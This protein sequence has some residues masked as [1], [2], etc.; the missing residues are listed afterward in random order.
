MVINT[1]S[2]GQARPVGEQVSTGQLHGALGFMSQ[3]TIGAS[4]NGILEKE[5][6]KAFPLCFVTC[7][8]TKQM[9]KGTILGHT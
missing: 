3:V 1:H 5:R 9:T 4:Q 7:H 6:T 2:R 8:N